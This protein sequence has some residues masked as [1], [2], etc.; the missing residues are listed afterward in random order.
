MAEQMFA[1]LMTWYP[2]SLGF[3]VQTLQL[4]NARKL[5][6]GGDF[7]GSSAMARYA[8]GTSRVYLHDRIP[9]GTL[10]PL[11]VIAEVKLDYSDGVTIIRLVPI[12]CILVIY[13]ISRLGAHS[14]TNQAL[15]P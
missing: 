3:K 10:A 6:D 12:L 7:R 14:T 13:T 11:V 8:K 2:Y 15:R 9:F 1:Y 5:V 4:P